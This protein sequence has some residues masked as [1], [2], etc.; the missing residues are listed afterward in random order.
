MEAT[1]EF[2]R[3][4]MWWIF[5]IAVAAVVLTLVRRRGLRDVEAGST[6]TPDKD[7]GS[8]EMT[9]SLPD[10]PECHEPMTLRDDKRGVHRWACATPG[11]KGPA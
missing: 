2:L 10:C 8:W 11:C 7:A 5:A 4:P 6:L 3:S 1:V 9:A